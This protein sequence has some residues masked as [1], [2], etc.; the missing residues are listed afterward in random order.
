MEQP[1]RPAATPADRS[2]FTYSVVVPVFNSDDVV[3]TTIDRITEVFEDAGL[4]YELILVNDGSQDGSWEVIAEKARTTPHVVALNLLQQLRPAPRQPRR[5]ARGHRR[6]RHHHGRRPAEP[7]RPGAPPDRRGDE[8]AA[9]SCS[10]GSSAS[11]RPATGGSAAADQHDQPA[12]LRPAARPRRLQLPDP[13]PRRRRPDLRV[14]DR[15]P[16]HHRSGADVLQQPRRRPGPPRRPPGRQ[17]QLRPE[18]DPAPRVRDPVQLLA[19]SRCGP[20]RWPA[21]SWRSAASCLGAFYLVR[22]LF[23]DDPGG[24]LDHDRGAARR[25]ST[26]SSIALLSMLGEY[27]VRT[28]NAVSAQETYHVIERVSS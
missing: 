19:R 14:P 28:L 21:S 2:S 27:V 11:R 8:R 20:P 1:Q 22:S 15:A 24:G 12:G 9:T 25:S 26:A 13:A 10:A 6:L 16:L 23:V 4:R 7:S 17:E 5:A 18:P 3:G